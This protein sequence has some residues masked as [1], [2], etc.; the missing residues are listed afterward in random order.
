MYEVMLYR[1]AVSLEGQSPVVRDFAGI[2][3]AADKV[4]YSTTLRTA[5]SAR[6]RIEPRFDP[7]AVRAL[8]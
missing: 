5:S 2:W 3:R 1:E 8:I 6:T 4:V 7:E